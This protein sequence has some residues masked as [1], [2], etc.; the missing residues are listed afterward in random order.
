M[1]QLQ[2][3]TPAQLVIFLLTISTACTAED[4][5]AWPGLPGVLYSP[6]LLRSIELAHGLPRKEKLASL[7]LCL[8]LGLT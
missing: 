4:Y 3:S 8:L 5:I 2:G 6:N 7:H 1:Q